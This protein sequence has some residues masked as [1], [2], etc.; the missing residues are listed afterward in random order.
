MQ[1][2]KN[3]TKC[4]RSGRS[5]LHYAALQGDEQLLVMIAEGLGQCALDH[6]DSADELGLALGHSTHKA[7]SFEFSW[8]SCDP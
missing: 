4:D 2:G 8:N 5:A 6:L 1:N 7:D 3:V